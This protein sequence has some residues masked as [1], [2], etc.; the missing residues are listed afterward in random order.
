MEEGEV[1][2]VELK[3]FTAGL[4]IYEVLRGIEDDIG[5]PI[6]RDENNDLVEVDVKEDEGKGRL[7][8]EAKKRKPQD[9]P[10]DVAPQMKIGKTKKRAKKKDAIDDL[11]SSL[12]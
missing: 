6:L 4:E 8:A 12:F 5:V 10:G 1:T 2:G 3:G 11:F 7:K 9:S